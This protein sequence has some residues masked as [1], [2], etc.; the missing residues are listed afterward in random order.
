MTPSDQRT[1]GA[2]LIGATLAATLLIGVA[3]AVLGPP[4]RGIHGSGLWGIVIFIGGPLALWF[5]IRTGISVER[6]MRN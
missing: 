2:G 6:R 3:L 5:G 4:E 1:F